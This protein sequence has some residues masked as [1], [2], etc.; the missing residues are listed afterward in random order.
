MSIPED[1]PSPTFT[2]VQ[3]YDTEI[4]E[5]WHCDLYRLGAVDEVDELGLTEAF[6]T[7]ICLV[8]WPDK[9]G[10]MQPENALTLSFK[11]DPNTLEKRLVTLSSA[12]TEWA[13]RLEAVK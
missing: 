11:T 9:L 10:P 7:A 2:L 4:G 6:E 3:V 13:S 1:V 12:N 5:V 8:E